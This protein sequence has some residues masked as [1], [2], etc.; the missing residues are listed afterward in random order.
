MGCPKKQ[1]RFQVDEI[2]NLFTF[3]V[4]GHVKFTHAFSTSKV[5]VIIYESFNVKIFLKHNSTNQF[6]KYF[7]PTFSTLKFSKLCIQH[8]I[9]SILCNM[10]IWQ[11]LKRFQLYFL[12]FMW[13]N[14]ITITHS[15]FCCMLDHAF[16]HTF[17]VPL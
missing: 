16:T 15:H 12:A 10:I 9:N 13:Q 7:W 14:M 8:T 2:L 6:Q 5:K 3:L 4:N 1:S 11:W 17:V